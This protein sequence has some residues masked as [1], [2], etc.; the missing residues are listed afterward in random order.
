MG[1]GQY[2]Y[3]EHEAATRARATK[4]KEQIF[5]QGSCHPK[6]NP[7]GVKARECRDSPNHP[8]ARGIVF[9]FDVS[10]SMGDL[11][12]ELALKTLPTFMKSALTIIPDA[13]VLFMAFGNA[14]EHKSPLQVGQF[15]SEDALIDQ[16][17]GW[18]HLEGGG[19]WECESYD[20]A[21]YFAARHTALD[22]YEK[23]NQKGYFFMTG[24]ESWYTELAPDRVLEVVGDEL[25]AGL[26]IYANAD[27]LAKTYHPFFLIPDP[28]RAANASTET[29]WRQLFGDCT[30]VLEAPEDTALVAAILIGI[31]EGQLAS[32]AAIVQKLTDLGCQGGHLDRVV[33][34]VTPYAR[35]VARGGGDPPTERP[36]I[37]A[38]PTVRSAG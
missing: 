28:A 12:V 38:R 32:D 18:M 16:W 33:K 30:I 20:L 22:C 27:E 4:S 14:Y 6:M 11:P 23:R 2:S 10:G 8:A 13:Q 37:N 31:R 21:M 19:E 17:L 3:E 9:A 35:A 34:A 25:P 24:D 1:G 7:K 5:K 26:G 15:E 36:P 29:N